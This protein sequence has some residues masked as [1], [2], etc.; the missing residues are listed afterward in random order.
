M[1]KLKI[2]NCKNHIEEITL[3]NGSYIIGRSLDSVIRLESEEVSRLHARLLIGHSECE[4]IDEGSANGTFIN[5]N[6]INSYRLS[7]NDIIQIGKF[8]LKFISE[9]AYHNPTDFLLDHTTKKGKRIIWS[10]LAAILLL[11]S[12]FIYQKISWSNKL[13]KT[14]IS[15]AEITS[16]YLAERNKEALYLGEY[17]SLN[18]SNLPNQIT[19]IAIIDRHGKIQSYKPN[20]S[21][22]ILDKSQI[23]SITIR[24]QNKHIVEIYTPIYYN[25]TRV[26]TLWMLYKLN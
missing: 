25:S 23:D 22:P 2:T 18:L 26:G 8:N 19:Q 16:F 24:Q 20:D 11:S 5:G 7:N 1:Y 21:E 3:D 13:S 12:F 14:Q 10:L 9:K 4:I 15:L 6:R 17:T